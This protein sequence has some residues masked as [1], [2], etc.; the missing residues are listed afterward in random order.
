MAQAEHIPCLIVPAVFLDGLVEIGD[1]RGEPGLPGG[2]ILHHQSAV[3]HDL[4]GRPVVI[5]LPPPVIS[6]GAG[7]IERYRLVMILDRKAEQAL[8][9]TGGD[10]LGSPAIAGFFRIRAASLG[11]SR[12]EAV[13]S[14]AVSISRAELLMSR[15]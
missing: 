9:F 3:H 7:G 13:L 2:R 14:R 5:G 8:V 4:Q 1:C 10:Q 15:S 11:I 12:C 6:L